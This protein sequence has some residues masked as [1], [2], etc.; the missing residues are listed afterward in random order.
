VRTGRPRASA[1][2]TY[3]ALVVALLLGGL[4]FVV[5]EG[6]LPQRWNP[7]P[8]LDLAEP[9][10]WFVDWRLS[11]LRIDADACARL[12]RSPLIDATQ[13]ADQ[14]I[15]NGCGWMNGVRLN[16]AG[17]ARV[18]VDRITCEAAAGLALWLAH[19]V[20][21]VAEEMFGAKVAS[22]QHFGSYACRNMRGSTGM[23]SEHARANALDVAGFT[24]TT[25]RHISVARHWSGGGPE[26]RFLRAVHAGACRTFRVALGPDYNA[27]HRDHFHYDR[28]LF[29]SCR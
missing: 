29:A 19:D 21:P 5:R 14:P 18:S 3:R 15:A 25:G 22:V 23:R 1:Y 16:A 9:D 11:T 28:G 24:L 27:A 12:L 26:A 4:L 10:P 8:P 6:L 7:L 17:G 2:A 20:Q 13:V